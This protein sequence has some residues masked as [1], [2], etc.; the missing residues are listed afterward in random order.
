MNK[1]TFLKNLKTALAEEPEAA[2]IINYYDELIDEATLNGELEEDVVARLGSVDAIIASLGE[3]TK[4]SFKDA[5]SQN[6]K[7][8]NIIATIIGRLALIFLFIIILS[9]SIGLLSTSMLNLFT[10]LLKIVSA[11]SSMVAFYYLSQIALSVGLILVSIY[12]IIKMVTQLKEIL[13]F[14]FNIIT[15]RKE[16][17]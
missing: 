7:K 8:T 12:L 10:S 11:S 5:T 17:V 1:K 9:F 2:E 4:G 16:V 3:K 6:K 15:K 13:T 14:L